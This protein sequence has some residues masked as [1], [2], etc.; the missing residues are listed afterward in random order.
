MNY[1]VKRYWSLCDSVDVEAS[2]VSEAIDRAHELPVDNAKAEFVPD[3]LNTD[4]SCDVQPLPG[5]KM[6]NP[7]ESTTRVPDAT[8]APDEVWE[9]VRA[10][11][12]VS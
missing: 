8:S 5:E 7:V 4:P 3:S 2:S 9:F 6:E 1:A 12:C 11:R 10:D